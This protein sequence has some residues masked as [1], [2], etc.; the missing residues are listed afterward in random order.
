M[1]NITRAQIISL[2]RHVYQYY[3]L[4][5]RRLPWRTRVTPYQVLVSEIM[6]QQTQVNR[7][8]EKFRQFIGLFPDFKS[9]A[10][11][12]TAEVLA[13][14]SGLGYNRR[15]L[16]LHKAAQMVVEHYQGKLPADIAELE[17]LP[18]V[19]HATACAIAVYAFNRSQVYVET[20]IRTVFIHHFFKKQGT[21]HDERLLPLVEQALDRKNP[22]R[23]YSALMDY[24]TMLKQ[25]Y[26]NAGQRSAHYVRQS[27][28]IGSRRQVRG[29]VLKLLLG[30]QQGL[31][32]AELAKN[33]GI[34]PAAIR[35]VLH[36]L[37][38]EGFICLRQRK[39]LLSSVK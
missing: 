12:T 5:Q 22:R 9:L 27:P 6:L 4:H 23:W 35:S 32:V 10:R 20:N 31:S 3:R 26:G 2:R 13:A 34:E 17:K 36:D 28:F 18:G 39:W 21:V 29:N 24:G 38:K 7:V 11:A 15:A 25:T 14:W 16:H 19:G 37:A 1:Q 30:K 33:A 8:V